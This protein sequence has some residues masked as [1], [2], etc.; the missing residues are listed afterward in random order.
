MAWHLGARLLHY[1]LAATV[2]I[3]VNIVGAFFADDYFAGVFIGV[4]TTSRT[5]TWRYALYLLTPVLIEMEFFRCIVPVVAV[6]SWG[7]RASLGGSLLLSVCAC[8]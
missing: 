6:L 4:G 8:L 3:L 5:S 2:H 7:H 1:Q